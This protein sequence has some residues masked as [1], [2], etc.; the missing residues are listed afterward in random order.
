M[1]STSIFKSVDEIIQCDHSNNSC[2]AILAVLSYSAVYNVVEDIPTF[3]SV[4]NEILV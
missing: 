3:E 1:V 4:S 2:L